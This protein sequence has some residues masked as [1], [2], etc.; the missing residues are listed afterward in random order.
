MDLLDHVVA[1]PV[2]FCIIRNI[3]FAKCIYILCLL[4][5]ACVYSRCCGEP[6]IVNRVIDKQETRS[7]TGIKHKLLEV[8]KMLDIINTVDDTCNFPCTLKLQKIFAILCHL[9][10][11]T[12]YSV[13]K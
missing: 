4:Q 8:E 12:H 13:C 9:K 10:T 6:L 5:M 11:S 1:V 3:L 7:K 2:L